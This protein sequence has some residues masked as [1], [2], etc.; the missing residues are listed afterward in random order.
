MMSWLAYVVVLLFAAQLSDDEKLLV[1][2]YRQKQLEERTAKTAIAQKEFKA[3]V[4]ASEKAAAIQARSKLAELAKEIKELK[5]IS[6]DDLF[7]KM[8]AEE[9]EA[10]AK[11]F[12]LD[13]EQE[14]EKEIASAGPLTIIR[15]GIVTNVIGLPDLIVE[16]Q[17]NTNQSIDALEIQADCFNKFGEPVNNMLGT[18]RFGMHYKYAIAPRAKAIVRAQM[19]L[20]GHAAKADV[21]ISRALVGNGVEWT[22]TK[23]KAKATPYGMAKAVLAE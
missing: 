15:M 7:V 17:N 8:K 12:R 10:Q 11:Q 14:R 21:W 22:Q 19:A 20:H 13:Q 23:E 1:A 18:N 9:R 5:K 2:E 6:E 4:K 16:V 3:A